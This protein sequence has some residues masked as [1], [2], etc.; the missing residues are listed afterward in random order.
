MSLSHMLGLSRS[1]KTRIAGSAKVCN[2]CCRE[3]GSGLRMSKRTICRF[4]FLNEIE[5]LCWHLL[6]DFSLA[7]IGSKKQ[8]M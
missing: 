3:E 4:E 2:S 6:D 1:E 7:A 8:R 5:K